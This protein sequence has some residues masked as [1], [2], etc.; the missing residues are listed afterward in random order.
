[1]SRRSPGNGP[2]IGRSPLGAALLCVLAVALLT[3][4]PALAMTASPATQAAVIASSG[5][6]LTSASLEACQTSSAQAERS[7]TF[8]GEMQ[9][10]PGTAKMQMRIDVL[11]RTPGEARFHSVAGPGVGA[12]LASSPGVRAYRLLRQVTNL[13]A[14]A[15]YRGA[16]R[17]R[18][19]NS[20]GHVIR[21]TELLTPACQQPLNPAAKKPKTASSPGAT[22]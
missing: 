15:A 5:H 14:P 18:W 4:A 3:Q 8:G 12:W 7:T 21:A 17:Y 2:R 1:M 11:E 13:S 20:R 19:L 10:V 9:F 22:A 16:V 6:P